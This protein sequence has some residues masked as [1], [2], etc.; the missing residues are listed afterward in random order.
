MILKRKDQ[1]PVPSGA[2]CRGDVLGE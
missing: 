2:P 1:V